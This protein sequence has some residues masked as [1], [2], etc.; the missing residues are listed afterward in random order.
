MLAAKPPKLTCTVPLD[1]L[2]KK[3]QKLDGDMTSGLDAMRPGAT[4]Q[5][6]DVSHDRTRTPAQ[7]GD[8]LDQLRRDNRLL[9]QQV[10]QIER[11]LEV[12]LGTYQ[13]LLAEVPQLRNVQLPDDFKAVLN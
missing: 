5:A 3:R 2:A 9:G 4:P 10:A 13:V 12:V 7:V 11:K 6:N 8:E 1:G